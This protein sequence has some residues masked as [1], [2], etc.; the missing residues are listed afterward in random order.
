[1]LIKHRNLI[2]FCVYLFYV[3]V[4]YCILLYVVFYRTFWLLRISLTLVEQWQSCWNC[5]KSI[6]QE[7]SVLLGIDFFTIIC[8]ILLGVTLCIIWCQWSRVCWLFY[9][10]LFVCSDEQDSIFK[11]IILLLFFLLGNKTVYNNNNQHKYTN[12]S[13]GKRSEEK[14]SNHSLIHLFLIVAYK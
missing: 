14:V 12:V 11:N 7:A 3:S 1:M 6:N 4:V 5:S 2:V 9:H 10:L 13:I 8:E